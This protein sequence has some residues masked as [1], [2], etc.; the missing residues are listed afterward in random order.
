MRP[1]QSVQKEEYEK[2]KY[3]VTDLVFLHYEHVVCQSHLRDDDPVK[4]RLSAWNKTLVN[5]YDRVANLAGLG[6]RHEHR[7]TMRTAFSR[8]L[9]HCSTISTA[10]VSSNPCSPRPESLDKR[11]LIPLNCETFSRQTLSPGSGEGYPR[12]SR[13]LMPAGVSVQA[14]GQ[15]ISPHT[16]LQDS[17]S[18]AKRPLPTF[19]PPPAQ[20]LKPHLL[21]RLGF[22]KKGGNDWCQ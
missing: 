3:A 4:A 2:S 1:K 8:L 18:S 6:V 9:D 17:H 13:P 19:P 5:N 10:H 20:E 15:Q 12:F 11:E 22:R 7:E 16:V 21:E 14:S